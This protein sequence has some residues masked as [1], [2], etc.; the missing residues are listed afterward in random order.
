MS[1]DLIDGGK[2]NNIFLFILA[3]PKSYDSYI[4]AAL[5]LFS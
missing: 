4:L 5:G 2:N 3:V 1:P